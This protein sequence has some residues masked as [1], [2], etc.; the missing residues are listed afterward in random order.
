M[1]MLQLVFALVICVY[2][3]LAIPLEERSMRAAAAGPYERYVAQV[4]WRLCCRAYTDV[5][6]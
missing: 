4:R 3:F 6:P 5:S 2:L 1:T